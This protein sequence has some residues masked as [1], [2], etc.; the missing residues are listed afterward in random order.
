ML[1]LNERRPLPADGLYFK[2]LRKSRDEMRQEKLYGGD[3][4]A[5]HDQMLDYAAQVNGHA[6]SKVFREVVS[7]ETIAQRPEIRKAI[8]EVDAGRWTGVYVMAVDRLSRGN[9]QDQG[10]I[11]DLLEV[12]GLF[13]VTPSGYFDPWNPNDMDTIRY[14]LFNSNNEFRAYARRMQ[15]SIKVSVMG[16]QYI[17]RYVPFGYDKAVLDNGFKT[18]RPNAD[19]KY[20]EMMFHWYAHEGKSC[21]WI[22][23]KLTDMGV[24]TPRGPEGKEWAAS[25]VSA[26]LSN[27]AYASVS[28]WGKH[29]TMRNFTTDALKRKKSRRVVE[30]FTTGK[31]EWPP[32]VDEDTFEACKRRRATNLPVRTDF[33]IANP[34]A[35]LLVCADCGRAFAYILDHG[36][37][38]Y[39]HKT[40]FR[41]KMKGCYASA[42]MERL[43]A[44]LLERI[45]DMEVE[46]SGGAESRARKERDAA[47]ENLE[48]Q[49]A[50]LDGRRAFLMTMRENQEIT[51]DEFAE[52]RLVI[53]RERDDAAR[54]LEA[55][56]AEEVS[57]EVSVQRVA[58]IRQA[59]QV[60]DDPS[61]DAKRVNEFLQSFI[62]K[63]EYEN[64]SGFGKND[65][66]RLTVHFL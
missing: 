44:M 8:E 51:A 47:I 38:R 57:E 31:G 58:T 41:C 60:V 46:L 54:R 16:G 53:S 61:Y 18:L 33:G 26:I 13:I 15:D 36:K 28:K 11:C 55:A 65:E 14:Q 39:S 23:R 7:G 32:L 22:A 62:G 5:K 37:Y 27:E 56:R 17:G 35:G 45:E 30:E 48:R 25:T 63:I 42:V 66:M 43:K 2:Y 49:I 20:V 52:R 21:Y 3:V 10:V 59:L 50:K 9:Q 34:L 64:R 29:K 1:Q 12:T 6:V 4:L 19:A 24:K 40:G